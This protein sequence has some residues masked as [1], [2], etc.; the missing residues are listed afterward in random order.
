MV[1]NGDNGRLLP[2]SAG[3]AEWARAIAKQFSDDERYMKGRLH[4]RNA[5]EER[6][7]WDAWGIRTAKLMREVM[8]EKG[9]P[10]L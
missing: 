2:L 8:L 4:A 5:F 6:L 3:G 9:C 1:A 10:P 7:N